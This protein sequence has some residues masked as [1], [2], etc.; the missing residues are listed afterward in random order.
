[1]AQGDDSGA[2][3][4]HFQRL[5][6]VEKDADDPSHPPVAS[7]SVEPQPSTTFTTLTRLLGASTISPDASRASSYINTVEQH[8]YI[9]NINTR[10]TAPLPDHLF[11]RGLCHGKHSDITIHAFG[12]PYRLH[13]IILD[14]AP[15]FATALT[16]PWLEAKSSEITI[17]PD[18]ID[19]NITQYGFELALKRLY[20]GTAD[21]Q[22][23]DRHAIELF[24][25]GCWLEM[26]DLI[27]ASIESILRQMSTDT[28]GQLITLVT[29]NYY[30]RA[31]DK[32]LASAKAMLCR[33]GWKMASRYWDSIPTDIINEIV[34]SDGFY[35]NGEWE[36]WLLAKRI[37]NRRLRTRAAEAGLLDEISKKT[38]LSAED[39]EGV[40]AIR[41]TTVSER[42]VEYA[43]LYVDP[44]LAPLLS[45]LDNGIH[46]VHLEFEQLQYVRMAKDALGFPVVPEPVV[47]TALWQQMELRQRVL[48]STES[49]LELGLAVELSPEHHTAAQFPGI[50][51]QSGRSELKQKESSTVT[52]DSPHT[53]DTRRYWIPSSD[54]NIV[55]GGHSDP[56]ISIS[57]NGGP[58]DNSRPRSRAESR[59]EPEQPV[60]YSTLPPFR[61]SAEFPSPKLIKEKKR[62]Y[63][64]TIF[65]AGSLWNIYI[66][67]VASIRSTKQLG[68]YLHRVKERDA[69]EAVLAAAGSTHSVEG[70]IG[71]L[72]REMNR[73]RRQQ[74]DSTGQRTHWEDDDSA[75]EVDT[76]PASQTIGT[77]ASTQRSSMSSWISSTNRSI[78]TPS[79]SMFEN[80]DS[81]SDIESEWRISRNVTLK[82]TNRMP[83]LPPYVDLRPTIKTYFKIFSPSRGG[84][85]LSVYE[86]APDKFNFS[87]SWGWK[88]STLMLDEGLLSQDE[89]DQVG[90]STT[91]R[92]EGVAEDDDGANLNVTSAKVEGGRKTIKSL[93]DGRLRFMVVIGVL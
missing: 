24:A 22:E 61:F 52:I 57:H 64:R 16:G 75:A 86:S 23:E 45:L 76:L 60:S 38:T 6:R 58:L 73:Q 62:A 69:E 26:P 91:G 7:P 67:K 5:P 48:N 54:C 74:Q 39:M 88:S 93:G 53:V 65:Y 32:I 1:M 8:G 4:M 9:R 15:F 2:T 44:E 12:V 3:D 82:S 47:S 59:G 70:R 13:R 20:R 33:D 50:R 51:S 84:R 27:E 63:S 14:R 30:G 92:D 41:S 80:D 40:Q 21:I 17:R 31:G 56:V 34:S 37:T 19:S 89:G 71:V 68:V 43:T 81:D 83:T 55:M 46:Y 18:E 11:T 90:E 36:R 79:S 85:M 29:K 28:L 49:E 77:Q 25:T 42:F 10:E 35:V 87:Q 66:Q 72:E 78:V